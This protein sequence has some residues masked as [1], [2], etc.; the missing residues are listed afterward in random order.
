MY[1]LH[2]SEHV[3]LVWPDN[4][5]LFRFLEKQAPLVFAQ[6]DDNFFTVSIISKLTIYI[7]Y[8]TILTGDTL[9]SAYHDKP[10]NVNKGFQIDEFFERKSC[11]E[12]IFDLY[13]HDVMR[14]HL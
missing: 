14:R 11:L 5:N 3:K 9:H 8:T 12:V 6:I 4:M 7:H 10:I 1:L 13:L 2:K